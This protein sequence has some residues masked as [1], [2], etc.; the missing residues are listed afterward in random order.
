MA[1]GPTKAL[2]LLGVRQVYRSRSSP[3]HACDLSLLSY[4]PHDD[5]PIVFCRRVPPFP[6]S[7]RPS[8]DHQAI[9]IT[10]RLARPIPPSPGIVRRRNFVSTYRG[11]AWMPRDK[12][13]LVPTHQPQPRNRRAD[14]REYKPR[15]GVDRRPVH[16]SRSTDKILAIAVAAGSPSTKY[17]SVHCPKVRIARNLACEKAVAILA[18]SSHETCRRQQEGLQIVRHDPDHS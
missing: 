8:R 16:D 13:H 7:L 10:Q 4:P 9:H 17:R 18:R 2:W 1:I 6:K 12:I 3:H 14:G 11:I 15:V 5:M